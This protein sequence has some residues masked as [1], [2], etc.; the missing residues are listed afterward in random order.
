MKTL[1]NITL[2]FTQAS[3]SQDI[4]EQ[5]NKV[6]K[7]AKRLRDIVEN[8]SV[9]PRHTYVINYLYGLTGTSHVISQDDLQCSVPERQ[10]LPI[11]QK[12]GVPEL[13]GKE[14]N[15]VQF[16]FST[17]EYQVDKF[18]T[19]G[20]GRTVFE[21]S[22]EEIRY[23]EKGAMKTFPNTVKV[24]VTRLPISDEDYKTADENEFKTALGAILGSNEYETVDSKVFSF[25]F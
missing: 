3:T 23:M 2:D 17:L 12:L 24:I 8:T 15:N 5:L 1:R 10:V 4:L 21:I 22:G 16:N 6:E 14:N 11:F 7:L 19:N 25:P 20:T 13:Q 9:E 18:M